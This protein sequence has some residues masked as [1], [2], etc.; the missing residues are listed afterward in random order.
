MVQIGNFHIGRYDTVQK[1]TLSAG[2][3]YTLWD[4]LVSRYDWDD[5]LEMFYNYAHDP[6][7]RTILEKMITIN[8]EK[9]L[10][11]MRIVG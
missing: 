6:E 10:T 8:P 2:E 9:L 3:A 1:P 7:L 11:L 4:N 5:S